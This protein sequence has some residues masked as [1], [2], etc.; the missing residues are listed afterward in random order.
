MKRNM[1]MELGNLYKQ[2][3]NIISILRVPHMNF[4]SIRGY[5]DPNNNKEYTQAIEALYALAY[6]IKFLIKAE[7]TSIDFAVMSLEGLWW[8]SD[9][10]AFNLDDRANWE[11]QMMIM[12]PE[13]VSQKHF[14]QALVEVRKKKNPD[15]LDQV[16]FEGYEEGLSAQILHHGPYGEEERPSV[17]KLHEYA[18][19]AGYQI[20]GKHH[21]IYLNS[22]LRT[23][24]QNLKTIIR[25][26]IRKH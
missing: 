14:N 10:R 6:R 9:I 24:P 22:P 12:Q 18:Q 16:Q 11:W 7:P 5:G 13:F 25:Q 21:E 3:G 26:P 1:I 8:A 19:Q 20:E 17:K 15:K 2:P 4:L 23:A